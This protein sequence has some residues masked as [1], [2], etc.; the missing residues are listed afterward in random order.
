[1]SSRSRMDMTS[2][3]RNAVVFLFVLSLVL[4]GVSLLWT[5]HE[6]N[7]VSARFAAANAAER[8]AALITE[9]KICATLHALDAE[10]PPAA[11]S[12]HPSRAYLVRLHERL[13][14]LSPDL[15]CNKVPRGTT[16][17]PSPSARRS[18][19]PGRARGTGASG[20]PGGGIIAAPAPAPGS[21][22][23]VPGVAPSP[24]PPVTV[25]TTATVPGSRPP[26]PP[27]PSTPPPTPCIV[28]VIVVRVCI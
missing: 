19:A 10:K 2:G 12:S 17:V 23:I 15:G 6:V 25:T 5:A 7:T 28:R 3:A 9:R 24:V 26:T 8:R 13:A 20:H 16:P 22:V 21:P 11:G 18:T 1:M 4:N 14:E 27:P